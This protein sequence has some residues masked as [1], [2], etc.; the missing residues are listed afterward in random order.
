MASTGRMGDE[1]MPCDVDERMVVKEAFKTRA[2]GFEAVFLLIRERGETYRLAVRTKREHGP[3]KYFLSPPGR[4][5]VL[6]RAMHAK[7]E[8]F[9]VMYGGESTP[10]D[11]DTFTRWGDNRLLQPPKGKPRSY[12]S[13]REGETFT[14]V[15][16][17]AGSWGGA[18]AGG[19]RYC[20]ERDMPPG[21]R[22]TQ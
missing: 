13:P 19:S 20:R 5:A 4:P 21:R 9:V 6:R 22:E 16:P 1:N 2:V 12:P 17:E 10:L 7:A 11:F 18:A 8:Q 15:I 14:T 3:A